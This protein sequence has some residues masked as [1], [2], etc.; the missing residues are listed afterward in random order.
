[1]LGV[2]GILPLL[3][4]DCFAYYVSAILKNIH[5]SLIFLQKM[6]AYLCF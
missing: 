1:M 4:P 2:K 6:A 5:N 3:I